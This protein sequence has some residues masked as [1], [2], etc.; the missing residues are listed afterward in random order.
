MPDSLPR[1]FAAFINQL[2]LVVAHHQGGAALPRRMDQA[3][4][5]LVYLRL[6]AVAQRFAALYAH[7]AA[8]TLRRP[9][10][11]FPGHAKTAPATRRPPR[12]Y[13]PFPHRLPGIHGWLLALSNPQQHTVLCRETLESLMQDPEMQ[14]LMTQAPQL[15]GI[16]APLCTM[17]AVEPPPRPADPTADA[18]PPR[19][20]RHRR[21]W[22]LDP[23]RPVYYGVIIPPM[24][25]KIA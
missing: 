12:P 21:Y 2:W 16:L 22:P 15:R 5:E 25:M 23:N 11:T 7:A 17:L 8:G 9:R 18:K 13:K 20:P 3:V 19:K 10:A 6:K 14:A 4:I 24:R 1:R